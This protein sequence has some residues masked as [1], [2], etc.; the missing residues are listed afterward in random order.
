MEGQQ[1]IEFQT[2]DS[3]HP[4]NCNWIVW[5]HNPA[6]KTWSLDSYKDILEIHSIEDYLV[7]KNSWEQ[8]LPEVN[9]GMF[10]LMRKLKTGQVVYPLWED[11]NNA[12]GGVWSF[13]ID[14][15]VAQEVWFKL[16]SYTIGETICHNTMESLQV[17]GISISPKKS[18]CI[19]KIW[20][21]NCNHNDIKLLN[22]KLG[23]FL[24]MDEV[25]YSTQ[26]N[27]IERDQAKVRRYESNK[28]AYRDAHRKGFNKF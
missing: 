16:C 26:T 21:N 12:N 20:N 14:K 7:L 2:S 1:N 19:I 5:Y 27:N 13:K 10:F 9:E 18:F 3:H 15:D 25:L 22:Q 24:N 11:P 17:N 23:L 4:L 8:C 6:D 28:I